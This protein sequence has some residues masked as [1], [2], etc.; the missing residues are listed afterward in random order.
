MLKWF[1]ISA[2]VLS[3]ST[4]GHAATPDQGIPADARIISLPHSS[5]QIA[6]WTT[7]ASQHYG[8]KTDETWHV[9]NNTS[10]AVKLRFSEFDPLV[11]QPNIPE[12]LRI[13]VEQRGGS[14][15]V[16][17]VQFLTQPLQEYRDAI[18][19]IGGELHKFLANHAYLASLTPD[20]KHALP[21]CRS[22]VGS[23][24]TKRRLK[25]TRIC[26]RS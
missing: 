4:F 21:S 23:A 10:Y 24:T 14:R 6:T 12:D 19:E 3:F 5:T 8:I 17:I 11:F 2:F 7:G 13:E 22:S 1:W 15:Q 20:Q 9:V 26:C 18:T 16:Y 25:S